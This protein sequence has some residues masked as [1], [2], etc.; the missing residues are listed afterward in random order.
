M[1]KVIG[2]SLLLLA[3]GTVGAFA[4]TPNEKKAREQQEKQWCD[5]TYEK[6]KKGSEAAKTLWWDDCSK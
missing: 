1:K 3:I 5:T 4:E 2:I 6:A